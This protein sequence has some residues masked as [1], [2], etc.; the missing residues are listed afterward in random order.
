[1][2]Q[3]MC[4]F[5][6]LSTLVRQTGQCMSWLAQ[7]AHAHRWPHG[8]ATWDLV[9]VMQ[10]AH[11]C[12][13]PMVDS[14]SS[15]LPVSRWAFASDTNVVEGVVEAMVSHVVSAPSALVAAP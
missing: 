10:M 6:H 12:V 7:P 5:I 4:T 13:P 8:T 14:S 3:A 2:S 15:L 9:P 1:M 11:V